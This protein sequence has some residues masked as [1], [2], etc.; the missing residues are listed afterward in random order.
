MNA[1]AKKSAPAR[2]KGIPLKE[3]LARRQ[4]EAG[5][6]NYEL[7]EKLGYASPN[8]VAMLRNGNMAFP[9][10]KTGAAAKALGV[11]PVVMLMRVLEERNPE[12]LEVLE[13]ILGNAMVTEM[14]HKLL[15]LVRKETRNTEFDPERHPEF[16]KT[17]VPALHD[18]AQRERALHE[19]S[20]DAIKRN[21]KPGPASKKAG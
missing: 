7:A 10:N 5:L 12:L 15:T 18:V 13:E 3:F 4:D 2:A 16:I 1:T 9:L 19:A 14:E 6:K 21:Y 20:M 8:V 11:D 17:V